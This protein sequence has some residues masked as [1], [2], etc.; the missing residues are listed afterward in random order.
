MKINPVLHRIIVEPENAS[1]A[2]DAVRRARAAGIHVE[3]DKRE[4]KAVMIGKVI[5]IGSTAFSNMFG[6]SAEQEG[7]KVGSRVIFAKYSGSEIPNSKFLILNDED[8]TAVMG[9]E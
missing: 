8:I 6:S 1:E 4:Q 5:A 9:D 2:D 7:I 3:L